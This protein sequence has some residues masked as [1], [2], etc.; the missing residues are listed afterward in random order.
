[1][2]TLLRCTIAVALNGQ[3]GKIWDK[4]VI[5]RPI[6]KSLD[7]FIAK[8]GLFVPTTSFLS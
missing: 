4:K 1:M 5:L 6:G 3:K 8:R 7:K 2:K